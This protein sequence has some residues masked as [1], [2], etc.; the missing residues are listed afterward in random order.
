MCGRYTTTDPL[1]EIVR[2]FFI[3]NVSPEVT[4]L[5]RPRYNIAPSQM[6]LVIGLRQGERTAAMHRW[7]LVPRWAKD[8]SIG[9]KMINARAETVNERPA[10]RTAF[11][12]RRCLIPADSFF[13]WKRSGQ[14]KQPYRIMMRDERPFAFAGLWE[15]W[16]SPDGSTV[17]RSCTI[18]T[19][20]P[21]ELMAE[22]HN[23]MPVILPTDAYDAWLDPHTE[24]D[25][26]LPLLRPYPADEMKCY[27]VSTRVN[28][29]ANDDPAVIEPLAR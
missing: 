14:R 3:T 5:Y 11:R 13:E 12:Y 2:Y 21:N 6:V 26:L 15:E 24:P 19:T 23:R 20:E 18:L 4:E 25:L 9:N 27:P 17:I 7:G 8:P 16:R 29:P 28:S 10:F 22:L 1:D